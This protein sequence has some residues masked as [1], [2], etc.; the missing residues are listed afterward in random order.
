MDTTPPLANVRKPEGGASITRHIRRPRRIRRA[1]DA[2]KPDRVPAP[3]LDPALAHNRAGVIMS[4]G[5]V[6]SGDA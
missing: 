2:Q 4:Q 1:S 6:E 5:D 3:A